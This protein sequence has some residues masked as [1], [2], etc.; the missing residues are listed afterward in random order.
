MVNP[1]RTEPGLSDLEPGTGPA[2]Q[3]LPRNANVLV[4]NFAVAGPIFAGMTHHGDIAEDL[5]TRRIRRDDDLARA[6]VRI[7]IR[8]GDDHRDGESRSV[9]R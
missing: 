2:Q 4:E 7:G 9:G 6:G 5:E 3:V 8:I 1:P